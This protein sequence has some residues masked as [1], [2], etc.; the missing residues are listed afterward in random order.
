MEASH[1]TF[2]FRSTLTEAY[3]GDKFL[4]IGTRGIAQ[5]GGEF[6]ELQ[7]VWT[8]EVPSLIATYTGANPRP[9]RTGEKVRTL[10]ILRDPAG[11]RYR[12]ASR[13]R[14]PRRRKIL[15]IGRLQAP[16]WH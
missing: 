13:Q 4:P 14:K 3:L 5:I 8:G 15:R 11:A 7:A 1:P 16:A 12:V 2:C 6:M 10:A 9:P